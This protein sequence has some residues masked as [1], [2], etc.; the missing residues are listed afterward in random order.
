MGNKSL[1]DIKGVGYLIVKTKN[2]SNLL[3]KQ[4]RHVPELGMNLI[5]T[6]ILDDEG[7]H[8]MF[9][10]RIWKVIKGAL[11]VAKGLK[12][13][14]LYTLKVNTTYQM[15]LLLQKKETQQIYG[16]SSWVT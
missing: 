2:G 7:Y 1:C 9:G 12:V 10:K 8:T 15:W 14:T 13:G 5:S 6:G 4:V 11:V 16:I 3:L